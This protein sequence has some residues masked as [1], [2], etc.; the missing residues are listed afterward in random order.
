MLSELLQSRWEEVRAGLLDTID[1]FR[2]DELAYRASAN[3][4]SVAET[5]LHIAHEEDIEVRYGLLRQFAELPPAYDATTQTTRES[6][7]QILDATHSQTL[8]Y[9]AGLNDRD[10]EAPIE[11]AWGQTSRPVDT[12]WHVIEHEIHHR[13]ELS[14]TLGLLGREGFQ[15]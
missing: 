5:M 15:A 2:D 1:M 14:L 3:A 4:Y 10:L 12:I 7:K 11:L 6:I 9:L 8:A 13:G